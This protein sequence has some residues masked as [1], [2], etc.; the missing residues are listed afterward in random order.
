MQMVEM[1]IEIRTRNLCGARKII[2]KFNFARHCRRTA[3][4]RHHQRTAGVGI[5]ARLLPS[6]IVEIAAQQ[7]G[8]K[9]IPR[10]QHVQHLY[11]YAGDRQ[12]IVQP[13]R[14][15]VG[16]HRAAECTA[17]ADQRRVTHAANLRQR[18]QCIGTAARDMK[19]LLGAD[20]HIKKMQHLLQLTGDLIGGDKTCF[21]VA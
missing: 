19:L 13:G 11:A 12:A 16:I 4:T 1:R 14:D 20:N 17:L 7:T 8:H 9:R 10:P 2:I 21:A 3:V 18:L 6:L 15:R 5:A